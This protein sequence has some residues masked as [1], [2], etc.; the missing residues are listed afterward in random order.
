MNN[1]SN[2]IDTKFSLCESLV[3][4]KVLLNDNRGYQLCD[5]INCC[6]LLDISVTRDFV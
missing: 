1:A 6:V 4:V 3:L 5:W 2:R